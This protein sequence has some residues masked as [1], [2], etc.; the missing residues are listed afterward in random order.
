M[1]IWQPHISVMVL[2][3]LASQQVSAEYSGTLEQ[4]W[5]I[6]QNGNQKFETLLE[7]QWNFSLTNSIDMT[8]IGR[9]RIDASDQLGIPDKD[10]ESY[11]HVN[12]SLF[13]NKH[14]SVSIREWYIDTEI[15]STYWRI[16]KQQVVWGQSD[17]LKVLDVINPQSYREFIL[18]DFEDSRIPIWMI[19]TEI[20]IGNDDSLQLLWIPDL[21]YNEFAISGGSYQPTSPILVPQIPQGVE[22]VQ[23]YYRKPSSNLKDSDFGLKYSKF[24][25]G[26][27]LTFNYFYHYLDSPVNYKWVDKNR[28]NIYS[29]YERSHL[30][31]STA[32]KAFG[33][34]TLRAEVG[35]SSDS[36]H[37]LD[38]LLSSSIIKHGVHISADLSSVIGIDWQGLTD[39]MISVQWFQSSLI[40]YEP[41]LFRSQTEHKFSLLYSKSFENEVWQFKVLFLHGLDNND[42]SIQS[43]LSYML[44]SDIKLW[45]GIDVFYGNKSGIFGQ[46]QSTDRV[47]IG[48][49]WG[50]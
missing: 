4:E 49:E 7:P 16:G 36:F 24:Y 20:P 44:E 45:T 43:N 1:N 19:N 30:V 26:W 23:S 39:T 41:G 6:N 18:D 12:G 46:F 25:Q 2:L 22:D 47:N 11:G 35:Y 33:D 21:S 34:F 14:I 15:A 9:I 50:F 27:D 29:L 8:F 13:T 31:G 10:E 17:G 3:I 48:V 38:N 37:L 5:S 32:S 40:D 42:G 28:V